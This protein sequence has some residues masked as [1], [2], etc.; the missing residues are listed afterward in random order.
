M[1]REYKRHFPILPQ[2][3]DSAPQQQQTKITQHIQTY[4]PKFSK[5]WRWTQYPEWK[6]MYHVKKNKIINT[7]SADVITQWDKNVPILFIP[8]SLICS[9]QKPQKT[10]ED[11]LLHA[12]AYTSLS[13]V[14]TANS[15]EK[16]KDN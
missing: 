8:G 13:Q 10:P 12:W 15:S 14:C 16:Q 5:W 4:Y 6:K 9:G 7:P 11:N 2:C 3:I 1:A